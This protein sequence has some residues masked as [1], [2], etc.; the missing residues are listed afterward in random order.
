M[1]NQNWKDKMAAFKTIDVRH[2]QGNFF[3]GLNKQAQNTPVGEG[4]KII[5][6]F[7]PHPLYTALEALG[8]EHVT[9]QKGAS[10]FHVYFYRAEMKEDEEDAPFKP[11]A[12]VV[13]IILQ[14]RSNWAYW[15]Q[16]LTRCSDEQGVLVRRIRKSLQMG[17][18]Y[19]YCRG[20]CIRRIPRLI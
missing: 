16:G 15:L 7:E 4:F 17:L 3:P 20:K 19:F 9:E 12:L 18:P 2:L 14:S 1:S 10:E 8:F 5:Q 13:M 6:T 11:L